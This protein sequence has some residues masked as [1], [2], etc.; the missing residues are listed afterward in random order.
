MADRGMRSTTDGNN[1]SP[2]SDG[3]E[4]RGRDRA[5]ASPLPHQPGESNR[6]RSRRL[7][8]HFRQGVRE[9]EEQS[10]AADR[11]YREQRRA[12]SDAARKALVGALD[13]AR[14]RA[15]ADTAFETSADRGDGQ[16]SATS[17]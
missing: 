10:V 17:S 11:A 2:R 4:R 13:R 3:V 1:A 14:V 16:A 9:G 15:S 6:D 5:G 8:E 7:A 12:E